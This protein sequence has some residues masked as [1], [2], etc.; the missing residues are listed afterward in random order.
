MLLVPLL[1]VLGVTPAPARFDAQGRA[2]GAPLSERTASYVL[3]ARL[4]PAAPQLQGRAVLTW[5]NRSEGPQRVLWFHAYWHP[6]PATSRRCAP[7]RAW[8]G[9]QAA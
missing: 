9:G 5:T 1:A 3:E 7:E 4:D 6:F 8:R 2:I